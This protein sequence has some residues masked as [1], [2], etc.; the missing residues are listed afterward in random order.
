[1]K[2]AVPL[3]IS[4]VTL[5]L[6][7]TWL[8]HIFAADAGIVALGG[9]KISETDV[10]GNG[11]SRNRGMHPLLFH[12]CAMLGV[13]A[14][15]FSFTVIAASALGDA[16]VKKT[17]AGIYAAWLLTIM[18]VQYTHPWTG[19]APESLLEMPAQL[20][21]GTCEWSYDSWCLRPRLRSLD[22]S[23]RR[24]RTSPHPEPTA[25]HPPREHRRLS[26]TSR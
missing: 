23:L 25:Q 15:A 4:L 13:M 24:L 21:V 6:S 26:C 3:A 22:S 12:C 5:L 1:M 14:F 11:T 16:R 7:P 19:S 8:S 18:G 10:F 2:N 20:G 17:V 9:G